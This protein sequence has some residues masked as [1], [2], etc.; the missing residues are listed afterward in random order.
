M[1][2]MRFSDLLQVPL[3]S[4]NQNNRDIGIRAAKIALEII[5]AKEAISP[6]SVLLPVK[7]TVSARI[8][9]AVSERTQQPRISGT[10]V[11][12]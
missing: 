1:C 7:L 9:S 8:L 2:N 4:V 6:Q 11:L 12:T 5:E 3:S 10:R